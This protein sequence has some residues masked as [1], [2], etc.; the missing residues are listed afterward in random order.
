MNSAQFF[1]NDFRIFLEISAKMETN[2]I[3]SVTWSICYEYAN[4]LF[5]SGVDEKTAVE[6]AEKVFGETTDTLMSKTVMKI[7]KKPATKSSATKRTQRND[8]KDAYN[9]HKSRYNA[10]QWELFDADLQTY[11]CN[12]IVL[13]GNRIPIADN[14]Y[15]VFVTQ[16]QH[17]DPVPLT[18]IDRAVLKGKGIVTF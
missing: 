16:D 12:N 5:K 2:Y 10:P 1:K 7:A 4:L 9:L 14:T 6:I 11:F 18:D 13:D 3:G 17:G 15:T 8:V